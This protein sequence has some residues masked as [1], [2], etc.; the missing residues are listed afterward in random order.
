MI[1]AGADISLSVW[2]S[3]TILHQNVQ[4]IMFHQFASQIMH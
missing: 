3:L 2:S 4:D 1:E